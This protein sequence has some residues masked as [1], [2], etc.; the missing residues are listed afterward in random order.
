MRSVE[1]SVVGREDGGDD[2][3]D[4]VVSTGVVALALTICRLT[5]RGK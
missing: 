2:V 1:L 3:E 4:G 5:C